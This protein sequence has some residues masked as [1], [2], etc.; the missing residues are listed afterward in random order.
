MFKYLW[1]ISTLGRPLSRQYISILSRN[2]TVR[3]QHVRV[4]KPFLTQYLALL[5]ELNG[6]PTAN[7]LFG[8]SR[9][10]FLFCATALLYPLGQ[11]IIFEEQYDDEV[12]KRPTKK[13]SEQSKID[14][15]KKSSFFIPLGLAR[16]RPTTY[17]KSSD[18]EWVS[19][20]Q[21][22]RDQEK[23]IAVRSTRLY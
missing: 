4:R 3:T 8:G 9:N 12:P 11:D 16:E 2:G 15:S 17:Y 23:C 18:P 1:T 5:R 10:I 13:L 21:F 19:F 20:Y 22:V 6:P 7:S 14:T